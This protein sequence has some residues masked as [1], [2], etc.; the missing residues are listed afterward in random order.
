MMDKK[1][2]PTLN[3]VEEGIIEICSQLVKAREGKHTPTIGELS[4]AANI[5]PGYMKGILGGLK[6]KGKTVDV[7]CDRKKIIRGILV[8]YII[9]ERLKKQV[10]SLGITV[11][12]KKKGEVLR[13]GEQRKVLFMLFRELNGRRP[14]LQEFMTLFGYTKPCLDSAAREGET[15]W[16]FSTQLKMGWEYKEAILIS[17][18]DLC[19]D[20]AEKK[21]L[22]K[23]PTKGEI[24]GDVKKR[25]IKNSDR[26]WLMLTFK[27]LNKMGYPI[28]Y[29]GQ[30][31]AK[32][33]DF[34]DKIQRAIKTLSRIKKLPESEI[35]DNMIAEH[36]VAN[37]QTVSSNR[38]ALVA[39]GLAEKSRWREERNKWMNLHEELVSTF[40]QAVE[41]LGR[42]IS[43]NKVKWYI[44]VK[45]D[46]REGVPL[47]VV[48]RLRNEL[49]ESGYLDIGDVGVRP[50]SDEIR[51]RIANELNKN[52][53][54]TV[55]KLAKP[56]GVTPSTV[57]KMLLEFRYPDVRKKY[58]LT[59][60][61]TK[62]KAER[63]VLEIQGVAV[64]NKKRVRILQL[65]YNNPV[66]RKKLPKLLN[67][68][69][70]QTKE[71]LRQL[72]T[73]N[74]V[75]VEGN[76]VTSTGLGKRVAEVS[77]QFSIL[78]VLPEGYTP[79]KHFYEVLDAL[80]QTYLQN[81]KFQTNA[82][83]TICLKAT[84]RRETAGRAFK[85]LKTLKVVVS[86]TGINSRY[87]F[88]LG[89]RGL[90]KIFVMFREQR[91]R[92]VAGSA[93]T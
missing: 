28:M 50:S 11:P 67:I 40:K 30:T 74:L 64:M 60:D 5:R 23:E 31:E 58:G 59:V 57:K 76:M 25:G 47:G 45:L 29:V 79:K 18:Y 72:K 88:S 69:H 35:T 1:E 85:R 80:S 37:R 55:E 16:W 24:M 56:L 43:T 8:P 90:M 75:R 42:N 82:L 61:F 65:V 46:T 51:K 78:D 33:I 84:G 83:K 54:V 32:N 53:G 13:A 89:G 9:D 6:K 77:Y 20:F 68:G 70:H 36:I 2:E 3:G 14:T 44:D 17:F 48:E 15:R 10:A 38:S 71:F 27:E 81:R 19:E 49:F 7:F 39:Q 62:R 66:E 22:R 12:I 26:T 21:M 92:R 41:E 34:Q 73:A 52:I 93:K 87:V 91:K 63:T 86:D 4:Q